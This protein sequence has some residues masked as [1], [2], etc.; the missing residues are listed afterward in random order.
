MSYPR[1]EITSPNYPGKY[2]ANLTCSWHF[3]C[4]P[5]DY[6]Y[7][8]FREYKSEWDVDVLKVNSFLKNYLI[9][10]ANKIH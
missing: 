1:G 9:Q 7:V 10:N 6:V 4:D 5:A 2:S 3:E 8:V